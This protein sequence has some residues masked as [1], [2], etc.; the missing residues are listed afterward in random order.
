VSSLNQ[1][2]KSR[3]GL[4]LG[5]IIGI[6]LGLI[7][8]LVVA[9]YVTKVPIPFVDKGS[10]R[11]AQQEVE[12]A[13]RNKDWNPNAGL[14]GKPA[15]AA[16]PLNQPAASAA[17]AAASSV[18]PASS[19]AIAAAS[20]AAAAASKELAAASKE[21]AAEKLAEKTAEKPADKV[22][23]KVADKATE[24]PA[25]KAASADPIGDIAKKAGATGVDPFTYFVQVG[26]FRTEED[27]QAHRARVA[28]SGYEARITEREQSGR[29]VWRVRVG[30]WE[31][32]DDATQAKD[33]L[34]GAGFEAAL[35]SVQR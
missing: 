23:D 11:T 13:K 24:K 31:R 9:L 16:S 32:K 5:I 28:M 19:T 12:E 29:T 17:V 22:A 1:Y 2:K 35:V 14:G 33:K 26:A 15:G 3:G 21:K 27:A 6:L 25:D 34:E 7:A 30:P 8:A 4:V 20:K 18:V 10:G